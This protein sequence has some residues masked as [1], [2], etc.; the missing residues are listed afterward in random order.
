MSGFEFPQREVAGNSEQAHY[1]DGGGKPGPVPQ[2]KTIGQQASVGCDEVGEHPTELS[3][4]VHQQSE[5]YVDHADHG[6]P[7]PDI[8]GEIARD[9]SPPAEQEVGRPDQERERQESDANVAGGSGKPLGE[10][11]VLPS[12]RHLIRIHRSGLVSAVTC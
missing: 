3:T 1:D 5:D 8:T 11:A 10:E 6:C 7:N 9:G 4:A 2:A 12:F